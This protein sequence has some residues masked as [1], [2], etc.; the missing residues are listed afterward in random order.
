MNTT[1]QPDRVRLSVRGESQGLVPDV[2]GM[3]LMDAVYLMENCGLRVQAVGRGAVQRQ[4][5]AAGTT[6][7]RGS[8]VTLEMTVKD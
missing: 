7:I 6:P 2:V 5:V 8:V 4:S 3:P 1:K